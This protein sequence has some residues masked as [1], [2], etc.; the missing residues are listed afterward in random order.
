MYASSG[1]SHAIVFSLTIEIFQ[2]GQSVL[3]TF[4]KNFWSH[5]M[6][7]IITEILH[8]FIFVQLLYKLYIFGKK[9]HYVCTF[10]DSLDHLVLTVYYKCENRRKCF[11]L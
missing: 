4:C 11:F 3:C 5:G 8:M 10:K 6:W 2:F 7:F 1:L 9:K